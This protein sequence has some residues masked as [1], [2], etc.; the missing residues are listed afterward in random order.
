MAPKRSACVPAY[1]EI[2]AHSRRH[3]D[4]VSGSSFIVSVHVTDDKRLLVSEVVKLRRGPLLNACFPRVLHV[5]FGPVTPVLVV[6][7]ARLLDP[8]LARVL[9]SLFS[10]VL[11]ALSARAPDTSPVS[12]LPQLQDPSARA[13]DGALARGLSDPF[14]P[15]QDDALGLLL[16]EG[17]LQAVL[18]LSSPRSLAVSFVRVQDALLVLVLGVSIPRK[19]PLYVPF[20]QLLGVSS[21]P[22]RHERLAH[23]LDVSFARKPPLDEPF[24]QLLD[25]ALIPLLDKLPSRKLHEPFASLA[26]GL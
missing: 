1:P 5:S 22:V 25:D 24:S 13:L 21:M 14:A 16:V 18:E 4:V 10:R 11:T 7:F 17:D 9:A 15:V 12:V 3:L 23:V 8:S 20:A 6:Q 2:V 19:P 26:G